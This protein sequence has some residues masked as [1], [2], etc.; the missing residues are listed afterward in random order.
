MRHIL[1]RC[2]KA[3]IRLEG[4]GRGGCRNIQWYQGLLNPG[5]KK[6]LNLAI[7]GFRYLV[8]EADTIRW[9]QG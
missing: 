3:W 4:K 8:S 2:M 5:H 1:K 7:Q 9:L 6:T